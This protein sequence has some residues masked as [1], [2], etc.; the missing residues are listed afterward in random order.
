VFDKWQLIPV[1]DERGRVIELVRTF[2]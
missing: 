1:L 2:F